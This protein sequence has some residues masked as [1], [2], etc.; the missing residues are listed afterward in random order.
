MRLMELQSQIDDRPLEES[1]RF[2]QRQPLTVVS[3]EGN[4]Y[5]HSHGVGE[6]PH[7]ATIDCLQVEE[8]GYDH[9]GV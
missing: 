4:G 8:N 9:G 1:L 5:G 6:L 3:V 2:A 7:N